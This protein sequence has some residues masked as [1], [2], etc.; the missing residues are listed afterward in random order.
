MDMTT[1]LL[2]M[3]SGVA[4]G[5]IIANQVKSTDLGSAGNSLAGLIGGGMGSQI[6][7]SL[8]GLGTG[9]GTGLGASDAGGPD[10]A[11]ILGQIA[12]GGIGGGVLTSI[13]SW[14]TRSTAN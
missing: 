4:G 12:T 11:N 1:L 13:M 9:L 5:H 3:L 2:Q 6:L 10:L 7:G 14:L 8:A